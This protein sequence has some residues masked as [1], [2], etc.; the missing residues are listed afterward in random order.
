MKQLG[1]SSPG[2]SI[3]AQCA[4]HSARLAL[5]DPQ[6]RLRGAGRAAS[7]LFPVFQRCLLT[8]RNVAMSDCSISVSA[9]TQRF[10][11]FE[12]RLPALEALSPDYRKYWREVVFNHGAKVKGMNLG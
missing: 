7:A 4:S 9:M 10:E 6:E 3:I 2:A 8:F 1:D 11:A 5:H 12:K